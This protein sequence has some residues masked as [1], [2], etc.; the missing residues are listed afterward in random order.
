MAI[1]GPTDPEKTGPFTN[2]GKLQ[3]LWAESDNKSF[4]WE[5]GASLEEAIAV[6]DKL[7]GLPP[8]HLAPKP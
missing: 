8:D 3:I 7:L 5:K 6:I 1:F 2:S 4:S